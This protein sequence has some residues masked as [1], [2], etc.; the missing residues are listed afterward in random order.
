MTRHRFSIAIVL[1]EFL[2]I[3][4]RSLS[5]QGVAG[6][7][8][9]GTIVTSSGKTVPNARVSLTD[10]A[11]GAIRSATT[12]ENGVFA[13]DNVSV[14]GP[15]SLEAR[16]VGFAPASLVGIVLHL[17][18]RL[19]PRLVLENNTHKL[20]AVLIRGSA[21]RDAGAGGPA[22][23]IPGEAI[24]RLPLLNRDLVGSFAMAPQATGA[25]AYSISG[26]LRCTKTIRSMSSRGARPSAVSR[27]S[28]A[29]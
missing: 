24:R 8:V 3:P 11:T 23:S 4:L 2:L 27:A 10:S 13:F 15:Y 29:A 17:G 6:A 19:E 14:G 12:R 1:A 22:Y 5:A 25:N 7:A 9:R 26:Q 28:R 20:D 21:L 18:D 16:A